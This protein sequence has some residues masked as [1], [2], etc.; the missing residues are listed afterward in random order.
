MP[1]PQFRAEG[2]NIRVD[3]PITLYEAVLG[4]KVRVPTLDGAAEITVPAGSTGQ[5]TLRLRGKG[6]AAAEGAGDL[7]VTL[8]IV[9]PERPD[10]ELEALARR[11][12]D[13]D[14]YDP[15]GS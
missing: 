12:R 3:V 1:H 10:P 2:R 15:R 9:L 6:V 8:R 14:P 7:L 11:L 5:R 13:A 4:G